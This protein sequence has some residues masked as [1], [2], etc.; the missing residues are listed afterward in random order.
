MAKRLTYEFVK[1][2]I[3]TKHPG[4]KVLSKKYK[5]S[6]T[7]LDIICEQAKGKS[8]NKKILERAGK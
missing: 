8:M 4:C 3:E 6:K 7:K 2:E 1:N 5:N